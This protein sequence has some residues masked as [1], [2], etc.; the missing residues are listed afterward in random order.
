MKTPTRILVGGPEVTSAFV[1]MGLARGE[2][3]DGAGVRIALPSP[4]GRVMRAARGV[5]DGL[6]R[7]QCPREITPPR[8]R[9]LADRCRPSHSGEGSRLATMTG[10]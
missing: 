5:G 2:A 4:E 6:S 9:P 7:E 1:L 3:G 8:L 10:S